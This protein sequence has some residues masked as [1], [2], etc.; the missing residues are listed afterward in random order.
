[1]IDGCLACGFVLAI[2]GFYLAW[3]PLAFVCGGVGLFVLGMLASVKISR[4]RD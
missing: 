1:M 4:E 3:P 2:V